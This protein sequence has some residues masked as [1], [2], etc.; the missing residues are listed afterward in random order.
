MYFCSFLYAY[1]GYIIIYWDKYQLRNV[2]LL[3]YSFFL[4]GKY[5]WKSYLGPIRGLFIY[6]PV[7]KNEPNRNFR[8]L[9]GVLKNNCNLPTIYL[10]LL[11]LKHINTH[12]YPNW[13]A[14]SVG[15][16]FRDLNEPLPSSQQVVSRDQS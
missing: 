6:S 15:M 3:P 4:F 14:C 1:R 7:L 10:F 11:F 9:C 2:A 16:L 5:R 12:I 8:G 13:T